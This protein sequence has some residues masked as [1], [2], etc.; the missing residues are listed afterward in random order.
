MWTVWQTL[1]ESLYFYR[2]HFWALFGLLVP[3]ALPVFLLSEYR[4]LWVLHNDPK[5]ASKDLL[6]LGPETLLSLLTSALTTL[7]AVAELDGQR[8]SRWQ[9]LGRALRRLPSLV[10]LQV[11]VFFAFL[12]G[13]LF[14]VLPGFW[15]LACLLPASVYVTVE[16]QSVPQAM[17]HS[18]T[19]FR[20][21]AWQLLTAMALTLLLVPVLALV[22][23]LATGAAQKLLPLGEQIAVNALFD[24]LALLLSQ[25]WS[26][27]LVRYYDRQR[28]QPATDAIL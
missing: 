12:G 17:Q 26:V 5:L 24:A 27:V 18:F 16:G 22:A 3:L 6:L 7:Y 14:F 20:P 11:L 23:G 13:L 1:G 15:L 2:R 21:L 25:Y 8:L 10:A 28:Q 4:M 19:V 9:L